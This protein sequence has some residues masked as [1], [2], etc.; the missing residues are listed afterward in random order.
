MNAD[1]TTKTINNDTINGN[2]KNSN[3]SIVKLNCSLDK[4]YLF[5]VMLLFTDPNL[6]QVSI[7]CIYSP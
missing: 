1:D 7:I 2:N 5:Q 3:I 6:L 4:I